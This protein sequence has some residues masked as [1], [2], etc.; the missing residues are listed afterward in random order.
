LAGPI[1]GSVNL[2]IGELRGTNEDRSGELSTV[3]LRR[4]SEP[5]EP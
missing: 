5:E 4:S 2:G 3:R 1:L